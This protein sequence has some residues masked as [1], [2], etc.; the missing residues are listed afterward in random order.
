MKMDRSA[1]VACP[2]GSIQIPTILIKSEV[3]HAPIPLL[4]CSNPNAMKWSKMAW[5]YLPQ[6]NR[7]LMNISSTLPEPPHQSVLYDLRGRGRTMLS[8]PA[9][10]YVVDMT[11]FRLVPRG[12]V[13]LSM[14]P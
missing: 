11:V 4:F 7:D 1:G 5:V 10:V 2:H 3:L 8:L 14:P 13:I 9:L 6:L 12:K